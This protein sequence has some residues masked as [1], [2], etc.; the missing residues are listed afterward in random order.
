MIDPHV[1]L[2]DWDQKHK[3]TIAHGLMI[4][5]RVGLSGV[6]DMPNTSPAITSR[7]LVERRLSVA[8]GEGSPVFYGL[9]V[10]LTADPA[11]I[12]GAVESYKTFF[13]VPNSRVGVVGLKMFAGHSVGNLGIIDPEKQR[14]VY[15]TLADLGYEG[16]LAVHCERED[17]LLPEKWNPADPKSHSYARPPI[18][19]FLSVTDQINFAQDARFKGNLHIAHV[20]VPTS[21][22]LVEAA[23][24]K[25]EIRITCGATPHHCT[26]DFEDQPIGEMGLLYKVNPPLR[27]LDCSVQLFTQLREG[28]IDWI[29]TDHAPHTLTEKTGKALDAKGNPQYMS[30]FP[31]LP[32][33]PH[34]IDTLVNC[35]FPERLI[36]DL[37][38]KNIG[39]AFGFSIPERDNASDGNM[40][41]EYEVDV[42][43]GVRG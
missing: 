11:Q 14:L 5:D 33:Y 39:R 13:P 3:E 23:R 10:G 37:T 38:H 20:S 42:Y 27:S 18:S 15:K 43:K 17:L 22:E 31:G 32:F 19:E 28:K 26:L 34:F 2:R 12:K 6:F 8:F 21:V 30:G 24:Q 41:R 9:Y 36:R 1:H 29:E 16:V 25:G 4:A 7:D 35:D 40:H